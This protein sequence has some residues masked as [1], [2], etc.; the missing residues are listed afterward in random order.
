[1]SPRTIIQPS[2]LSRGVRRWAQARHF[3]DRRVIFSGIQPTGTPHLGNYIGAIHRWVRLQ[4]EPGEVSDL[5]YSVVDL[6]AITMPISPE[7]LRRHRREAMA[8]LLAAGIDPDRSTLFYQSAIPAHSELMW[9]L[10]CRASTGYL[11]RMTQWKSKLS[12]A[13][14][15]TLF[16]EDVRSSLKLGL[17]SYPVLQA[18]DILLY[19][20]TH[21]PV[22]DDQRQHLEFARE[23]VSNFN[24]TYGKHLVSPTTL[25]SPELR[26]MSLQNPA[27][28]MSK[29]DKSHWSRILI[30]D[31]PE[32]INKKVMGAVTDSENYVSYD[33]AARP[34]VSNLLR[35]LSYFDSGSRTPEQ[36]AAE[37]SSENAGLGVLK[38]SVSESI[39]AAMSGIRERYLQ[40][41]AEDGG[42]FIDHVA[43][44]GARK[45]QLRADETMAI[46]RE[47]VGL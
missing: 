12:V 15:T 23:C 36:L 39:I 42:G 34:G 46:V 16:D 30:T 18:A 9:I 31:T 6:H 3:S 19:R 44:E 21:V 22:G 17:F 41:L 25:S 33:P 32:E 10:A 13:S 4:D 40:L 38:Q 2:R 27:Q 26:V 47:A 24:S 7:V 43:R 5:I 35:L 8:S 37:L 11:S 29:S 28:K 14:S 20:A 45:A 1:M